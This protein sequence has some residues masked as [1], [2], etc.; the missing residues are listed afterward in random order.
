MIQ[1]GRWI[2]LVIACLV[3]IIPESGPHLLFVTLY[4]QGTVPL[5]VLVGSSIVQDG[6]GLLPM[7]AH[8]RKDFLIIKSVA[9]IAG[10]AVGAAMMI[11]GF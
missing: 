8:S 10:L 4:V 6:H 7:L 9:L 5:S 2:V 11:L 3:G 1:K